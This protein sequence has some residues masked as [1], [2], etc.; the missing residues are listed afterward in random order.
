MVEIRFDGVCDG[1]TDNAPALR[2]IYARL[3]GGIENYS[4]HRGFGFWNDDEIAKPISAAAPRLTYCQKYFFAF[5][6][7]VRRLWRSLQSTGI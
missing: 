5:R 2:E 6:A 1:I 7:S 3:R 4:A